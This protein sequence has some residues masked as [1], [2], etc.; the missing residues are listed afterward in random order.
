MDINKKYGRYVA[1]TTESIEKID[2]SRWI[3]IQCTV[4]RGAS[5]IWTI[6]ESGKPKR[7]FASSRDGVIEHNKG[8]CTPEFTPSLVACG[9]GL[10]SAK[11]AQ[12]ILQKMEDKEKWKEIVL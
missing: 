9:P 7:I 11:K 2:Q 1:N 12:E 6:I 4:Q 10:P 3:F 8:V 5:A